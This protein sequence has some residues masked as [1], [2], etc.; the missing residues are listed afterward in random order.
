M[1]SQMDEVEHSH[2]SLFFVSVHA[3]VIKLSRL[4]PV[5]EVYRGIKGMKLPKSFCVA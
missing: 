3:G 5:C 1:L 4:Q 2:L